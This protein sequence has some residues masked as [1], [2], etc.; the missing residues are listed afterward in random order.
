MT[1]RGARPERAT[2]SIRE[3]AAILGSGLNQTYESA[4]HGELSKI[5]IRIGS[6][7]HI[8][9]AALDRMLAGELPAAE[10]ARRIA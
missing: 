6:R 7:I 5:A 3:T 9:R 8:P 1:E 2:Y 4:K 10:A